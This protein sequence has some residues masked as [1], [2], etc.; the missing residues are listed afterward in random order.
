MS[1]LEQTPKELVQSK[2]KYPNVRAFVAKN[3]TPYYGD[4]S[5]LSGPTGNTKKLWD[6]CLAAMREERAQNGCRAIDPDTISEINSHEAGYIDRDLE[7]IV[8]L[9]TDELLKRAIKPFG[10]LRVVEGALEERG[11]EVNPQVKEV[12]RYAKDHNE[13]V[14]SAYDPEIKRYRSLGILT[15]LPDNYARGR[16]IGDYRRLAL[17]GADQLIAWKQA[18]KLAIDGEMD[19]HKIR[20]REEVTDQIKALK[21]IKKMGERYGLDLSRPAENAREAVQWVYMAY[22]AAVKEQDGAAMSLGNVSSFL[23]IYLE[24]DLQQGLITEAEAQEYIDHFVMKLRMVRQPAPRRLRRDLRRRP[25]LDHGSPR[26]AVRRRP[27]QGHQNFLP[28]PAD[29]LQSGAFPGTEHHGAL[30]RPVARRIQKILRS[31]LHRHFFHSIRK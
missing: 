20:L 10:G 24:H 21:E 14:F 8:G 30:V 31:G 15:G 16:I 6:L 27:H 12:F 25:H 17:Y 23:D 2:D 29:P 19:E 18:D 4:A 1:T 3:V 7:K 5:F 22:L 11:I 26:R 28:L 13:G 9:Q